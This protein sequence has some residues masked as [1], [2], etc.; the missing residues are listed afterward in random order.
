MKDSIRQ[1]MWG[2]QQHFRVS[3][4]I[5]VQ[6][7][8]SRIGLHENDRFK[9]LLIGIATKEELPHAICIEPED[10]P[11][12]VDDLVSIKERTREISKVDPEYGISF[13]MPGTMTVG[14]GRY[15]Y[16]HEPVP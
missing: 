16:G 2:F 9:V 12:V 14:N 8:L 10:G 7:V 6:D 13:P 4:E 1:F 11:L 3:V 15:S 5:A